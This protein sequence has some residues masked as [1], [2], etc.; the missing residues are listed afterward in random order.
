MLLGSVYS[1]IPSSGKLLFSGLLKSN[2]SP[3]LYFSE[4]NCSGKS[5][6]LIPGPPTNFFSKILKLC[7]RV[8]PNGIYSGSFLSFLISI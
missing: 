2:L 8:L 4:R 1:I 7:Q 3:F 6:Y 5:P